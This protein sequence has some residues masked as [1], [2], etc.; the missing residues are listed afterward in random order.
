MA[1]I[2]AGVAENPDPHPDGG[3]HPSPS[4]SRKRTG[5]AD[6]HPFVNAG[7]KSDGI[8]SA[9]RHLLR[10]KCRLLSREAPQEQ[11]PTGSISFSTV[12]KAPCF[13]HKILK[14]LVP[15]HVSSVCVQRMIP[16]FMKCSFQLAAEHMIQKGHPR[17]AGM[18]DRFSVRSLRRRAASRR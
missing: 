2:T 17:K 18:A 13:P 12:S 11:K 3:G 7:G 4:F 14:S 9:R 6:L 1:V 8:R 15:G 10:T 16:P 5:R